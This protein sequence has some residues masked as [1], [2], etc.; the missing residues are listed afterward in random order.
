MNNKITFMSFKGHEMVKAGI[1]AQNMVENV[2]NQIGENRPNLMLEVFI[3]ATE[4][5]SNN[6]TRKPSRWAKCGKQPLNHKSKINK[7]VVL[8]NKDT[9]FWI[10]VNN[11]ECPNEF[12]KFLKANDHLFTHCITLETEQISVNQLKSDFI[13]LHI[14]DSLNSVKTKFE[15]LSAV[16]YELR[17]FA[18]S[19]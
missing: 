12:K 13:R 19:L 8:Y 10:M 9:N 6:R 14:N 18:K 15:E 1:E 7:K 11:T 16:V 17:T 3:G 4:I 5:P 2:I